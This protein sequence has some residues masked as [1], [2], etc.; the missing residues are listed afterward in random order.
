[1]DSGECGAVF[2]LPP[3]F[4]SVF[5]SFFVGFGR[6]ERAVRGPARRHCTLRDIRSVAPVS[7]Q[8]SEQ[9]VL[10]VGHQRASGRAADAHRTFRRGGRGRVRTQ[11][12]HGSQQ[13]GTRQQIEGRPTFCKVCTCC[14]SEYWRVR[15]ARRTGGNHSIHVL[16][17]DTF[18]VD[19]A[20]V[21]RHPR[22]LMR[23]F[24]AGKVRC[25]D[26]LAG[27][28]GSEKNRP[29]A[30]SLYLPTSGMLSVRVRFYFFILRLTSETCLFLL[31]VRTP[32]MLLLLLVRVSFFVSKKKK[33]A[34]KKQR[35]PEH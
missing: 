15:G 4:A 2:L 13:E 29:A 21:V 17:G 11:R 6:H 31:Y 35:Q 14:C 27:G 20:G 8:G 24:S 12:R 16:A 9:A 22:V 18:V 23:A 3:P 5:F 26:G 19:D 34:E 33:N 10:H 1:M 7:P 28:S 25:A 32:C 30:C